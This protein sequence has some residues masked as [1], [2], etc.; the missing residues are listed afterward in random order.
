MVDEYGGIEGLI[1]LEDVL[2]TMVGAEILD[3][4]DVVA[5]MQELAR[6]KGKAVLESSE[7]D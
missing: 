3:E 5:D 1:T 4:S 7:E 2:E 6:I